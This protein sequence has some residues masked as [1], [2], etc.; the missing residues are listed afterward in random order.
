MCDSEMCDSIK[1]CEIEESFGIAI[2]DLFDM[3]F[4]NVLTTTE[5]E[6]EQ[7]AHYYKCSYFLF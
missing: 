3:L 6:C 1:M 5:S 7:C 4:K 2:Y